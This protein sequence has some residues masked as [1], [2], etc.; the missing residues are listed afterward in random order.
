MAINTIVYD[1][2][3]YPENSKTITLDLLKVVPV[4]AQGD[5]KFL[6]TCKTNAYSDFTAKTVIDDIFI[7]EFLCGWCKSS[8]FAGAVFTIQI[9]VND[10]LK[11][12]INNASEYYTVTLAAGINLTSDAV[13]VD[14]Q[15]KLRGLTMETEDAASIFALGYKNCRCIFSNSRFIIKS[16]TISKLLSGDTASSVEVDTTGSASTILGFDLPVESKD[17][18]GTDIREVVVS[19]PYTSGTS[20]ISVE[21]G[22]SFSAGDSMYITD[23]TNSDY[24]TAV[25][26][27]DNSIEIA[28]AGIHGF[29]GI[30]HTYAV[31]SKVQKLKYNDP[32]YKPA[33][34][35]ESVDD[36]LTWGIL[37][38][39]NQIDYSG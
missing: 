29:D 35:L 34:C 39:A 3:G 23:G 11:I 15:T 21:S 26:G 28:V 38:L 5:E 7:Q 12:K 16:G 20:P 14:I 22:L 33:S 37:S 31:G 30:S 36:A 27:T 10:E 8:G 17:L 9:G 4:G 2:E 25:S 24:F 18:A 32:E 6:L 19:S 1:L 13:A